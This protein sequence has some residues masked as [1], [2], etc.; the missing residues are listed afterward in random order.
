MFG[1]H[2]LPNIDVPGSTDQIKCGVDLGV[3]LDF[4]FDYS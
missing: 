2:T 3:N 4:G 1:P